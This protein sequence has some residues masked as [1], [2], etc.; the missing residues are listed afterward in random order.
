LDS[1]VEVI[2]KSLQL[3]VSLVD[4]PRPLI[5]ACTDW[6]ERRPHLAGRLGKGVLDGVL[7]DGWVRRRQEDRALALTA[8]GRE[9]FFALGIEL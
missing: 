2:E 4:S 6:T 8:K 9:R 3:P 7:A 1:S 5:R